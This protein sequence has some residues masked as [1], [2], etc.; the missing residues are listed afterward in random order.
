MKEAIR[1][2]KRQT[3]GWKKMFANYAFDTG[4]ASRMYKELSQLNR[5]KTQTASSQNGQE[6]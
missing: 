3:P 2:V 4:L 6:V 1:R 5:E